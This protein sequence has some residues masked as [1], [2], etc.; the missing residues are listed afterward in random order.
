MPSNHSVLKTIE[1]IND[2]FSSLREKMGQWLN[3]LFQEQKL[4]RTRKA[5][6]LSYL[7]ESSSP[8]VDFFVLIV[9]SCTIATLGLVS[10][11]AAVI[12]G[13]M[14]VAPLMSPILG[15]SMA[16]INGQSR[17]FRRSLAALTEGAGLAILLSLLLTIIAYRLPFGIQASIPDEVLARTSPSPIDLGIALAGGAAAAYA[18][19]HPR[20]TAALPGV[21]IATALMPPLC[22]VG[23]GIAFLNPAIFLGALLLFVTNL[24]TIAFAGIVTFAAMGFGPRGSQEDENM[25]RSVTIAAFLVLLIGLLLAGVAWQSIN[26]AHMYNQVS[27]AIMDSISQYTTASLVD[28]NVSTAADVKVIKVTLRTTHQL[29]HSQVLA[30]QSDI[31]DRL[32]S[33]VAFELVTIPMQVLDPQNTPTP[34]PTPTN[35]PVLSPTPTLTPLPSSTPTPTLEPSAT[36]APAFITT[37]SRRGADIFEAPEGNLSFHLPENSAVWVL[38]ENQ[39]VVDDRIWVK[40]WDVFQ[41]GG[42][43]PAAQ[44]DLILP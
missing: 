19:A 18:L 11:S 8:G 21:A 25:S 15:L 5:D 1:G 14:L 3:N 28:L 38:L 36:P 34:T 4:T 26:E 32:Q 12:I 43:L 42:W 17:L 30:L 13:A 24:V 40:V 37:S 6:V 39:Q 41:R 16:S 33:P 23:I 9:L 29:G 31:S 44:L 35:T 2:V 10:D 7:N 22:T 20:L 27:Q